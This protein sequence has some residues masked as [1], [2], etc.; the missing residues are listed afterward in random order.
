METVTAP[1]I[2]A[3]SEVGMLR[4]VIVYRPDLAHAR[5]SSRNCHEL[6][7]AFVGMMRGRAVKVLPFHDLLTATA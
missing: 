6:F 1:A 7:D 2:G 5:L 4:T 3:Q